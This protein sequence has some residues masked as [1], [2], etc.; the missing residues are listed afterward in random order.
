MSAAHKIAIIDAIA[1]EMKRRYT[2]REIDG[3]LA[4]F[5]INTPI[6]YHN[7][8]NARMSYVKETLLLD[9]VEYSVLLKIADD[10]DL[11]TATARAATRHPPRYWPDDSKFR[12]FIS[13]ISA[14]K[15]KATRLREC[16]KPYHISGFVAHQDIAPTDLWQVEIER[17][18]HS[19][20][21][22]LAFITPGFSKSFWAQQEIGFAVARGVYI[23]S[24]K[25]GEDPVGFISKQQ[26]LPRRERT[27]EEIA[28]EVNS[29]LLSD[30]LTAARLRQVVD[31][32][33]P[34]AAIDDD[35]PF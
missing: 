6:E 30:D 7:Y 15:I 2:L 17:A 14:D 26:A 23:I 11:N 33:T 31:A 25:M 1:R 10:L 21:A 12:L 32:H 34:K 24:F 18:L 9:R 16:L 27:A 3:Y 29:L 20:D 22:F 5:K 8:E 19:M 4:E 35:I 13:H 28:K